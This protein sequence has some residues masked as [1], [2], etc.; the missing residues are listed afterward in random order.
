MVAAGVWLGFEQFGVKT[1]LLSLG[2]AY[3]GSLLYLWRRA[4]DRRRSGI[5]G[6]K[7]S[8]QL[9]LTGAMIAVSSSTAPATCSP[10]VPFRTLIPV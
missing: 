7:R 5:K 8:L 4:S 6:V 2:M 1:V 9:K 10:S 3:A